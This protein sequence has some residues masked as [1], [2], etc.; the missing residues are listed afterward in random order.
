MYTQ[1][2]TE[3]ENETERWGMNRT[4]KKLAF[5]WF[6]EHKIICVLH[7][8]FITA[9]IVGFCWL[10]SGETHKVFHISNKMHILFY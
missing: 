2:D 8:L 3:T 7:K 9:I 6:F 1:T 5:T 10:F 4:D